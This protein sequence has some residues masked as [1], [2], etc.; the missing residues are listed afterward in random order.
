MIQFRILDEQLK[1]ELPV[2]EKCYQHLQNETPLREAHLSDDELKLLRTYQFL[3]A[4]PMLIALNLDE[5]Q[6]TDA[7]NYL[8]ELAK[9]RLS[10]N[11]QALAFF[12]KIEMEMSELPEEDVAVFMN[13]YG[14]KESALN[15]IIRASYD[16][17]GLHSFIT[18]GEDECRTW[19]IRKGMTAQQ[20]AGEVHTDF[21][22]K[23][24]RAEVVHYNHFI[25]DGSFAKAKEMGH[26]RLEGK[27]YVVRDGDIISVRHG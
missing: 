4:K 3:S 18:V 13:E 19:T 26:W 2:L 6:I 7:N 12:G 21:Y 24:I 25:E 9:K 22:N 14:I 11:T 15:N 27:E 10:K 23:F 17:L 5:N 8:D 16:L 20:A 1:R